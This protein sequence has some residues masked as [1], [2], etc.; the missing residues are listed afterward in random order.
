VLRLAFAV[1]QI[2]PEVDVHNERLA[3]TCRHP[4]GDLAKVIF[5]EG[6][7]LPTYVLLDIFREFVQLGEESLTVIEEPVK[8]NLGEEYGEIL[9]VLQLH[10]GLA[11]AV[12]PLHIRPDAQ[13]ILRQFVLRNPQ[14][15]DAPKHIEKVAVPLLGPIFPLVAQLLPQGLEVLASQ[16]AA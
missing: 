7:N 10:R 13:V 8:V 16:R 9:E 2:L 11:K 4:E 14:P 3:R 15:I 6:R 1:V 5:G 12:H